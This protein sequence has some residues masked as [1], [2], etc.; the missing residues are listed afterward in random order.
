[1][2]SIFEF[3]RSKSYQGACCGK[4]NHRN[5]FTDRIVDELNP[6]ANFSKQEIM[7]LICEKVREMNT[8]VDYLKG[9]NSSMS[10]SS[11]GNFIWLYSVEFKRKCGETAFKLF[12]FLFNFYHSFFVIIVPKPIFIK[13]HDTEFVETGLNLRKN[14]RCLFYCSRFQQR[15]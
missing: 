9:W 11:P 10:W 2:K 6:E 8:Y 12:N 14:S 5:T 4:I 15:T 1:M 13:Y 3:Y 7:K